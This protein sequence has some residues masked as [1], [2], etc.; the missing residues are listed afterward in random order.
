[1]EEMRQAVFLTMT[2]KALALI[3]LNLISKA[4]N[5]SRSSP[6]NASTFVSTTGA[7]LCSVWFTELVQTNPSL[8]KK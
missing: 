3:L 8:A 5:A 1:M 2:R 6:S 4:R 7:V